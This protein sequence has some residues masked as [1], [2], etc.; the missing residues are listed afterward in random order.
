MK[1]D[2][3]EV[4]HEGWCRLL[5]ATIRSSDGR[6]LRREIEDH[7]RAACVLP[8]DSERRMA[9]L[10]RQFRAPVFFAARTEETLEAIA[11]IIEGD[12][13]M[14]CAQR[15]VFEEAGLKLA[16]LEHVVTGW[17]MPGVSTER[18]DFYLAIYHAADR[19][20]PGGGLARDDERISVVEMELER[21]AE[22]ADGGEL[23]DIKTLVLVQ[24]LRI[25][26][27]DLFIKQA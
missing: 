5:I 8:Y 11:G 21:L 7:G 3:I 10:V 9:I 12:D 1:F 18:M 4:V 13:P 26:R 25:R 6:I 15:E 22:M 23:T 17:T 2:E 20:A 27:P 24:T 14:E 19:I 16:K